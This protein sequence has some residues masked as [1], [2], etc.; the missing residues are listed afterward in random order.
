M[1]IAILKTKKGKITDEALRN[2]FRSNPDGAGIAY[3]IDGKLMVEKG[4]FSAQELIEKVRAAEKVCDGAMLIHC[5][6]GTSGEKTAYNTHPFIVNDKVCLIHNGVL[7]IDVPDNSKENDTQIFIKRFLSK[8]RPYDLMHNKS[9]HRMIEELIGKSNKFVLLDNK[10]YYKILNEKAGHWKDNVW[11]SNST[12]QSSGFSY[13]WWRGYDGYGYGHTSWNRP[14]DSYEDE[15]IEDYGITVTD[16][17]TYY[18]LE[19]AIFN[20]KEEEI[21]RIG[22]LPLYCWDTQEVI[23]IDEYEDGYNELNCDYL[24]NINVQLYDEYLDM[25]YELVDQQEATKDQLRLFA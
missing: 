5:R 24:E 11:Y 8:V 19:D 16:D 21:L 4:I 15:D 2:S 6:I 7:D 12:Y 3:T 13:K 14:Y 20:L 10:G 1:C 18:E 22:E 17:A 9:I 23:S 25:Y